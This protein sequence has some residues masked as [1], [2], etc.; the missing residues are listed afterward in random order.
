MLNRVVRIV[1]LLIASWCVM[2]VVHE[3]GHVIC[4]WLGG[5]TLRDA[6]LVPWSLPYSRFDP[7]PRPLLTC[8][9]GPVLGVLVPLSLAAAA[10]QHWLWF[11][12]YFCLLA[13]G[14]YL[15]VAWVSGG[16]HLD[17]QR[18]LHHGAHPLSV[19]AFS[20]V[21]IAGGYVGFRRECVRLLF[22]EQGP[23][24]RKGHVEPSDGAESR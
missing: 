8:W 17:T 18:L 24:V 14:A 4:G 1:G 23:P 21:A 16:Q 20:A 12:A 6:D 5:G 13:N 15:A 2:A 9:G 7:D 3:S 11:I 19:V 10:R 22:G